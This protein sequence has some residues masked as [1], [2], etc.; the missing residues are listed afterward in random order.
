[1]PKIFDLVES[2]SDV[3]MWIYDVLKIV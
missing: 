1:M 2:G 3:I